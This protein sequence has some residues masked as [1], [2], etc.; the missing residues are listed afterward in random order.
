MNWDATAALFVGEPQGPFPI[1]KPLFTDSTDPSQWFLFL[2]NL[3]PRL[4]TDVTVYRGKGNG[5]ILIA[6]H[7]VFCGQ[8]MINNWSK[9]CQ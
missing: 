4:T 7:V 3:G 9:Y 6:T 2:D 5:F 8:A 1:G